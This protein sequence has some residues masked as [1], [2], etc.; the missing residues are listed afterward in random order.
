MPNLNKALKKNRNESYGDQ[1][2]M[3]KA[4]P[5][6]GFQET[7]NAANRRQPTLY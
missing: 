5:A 4:S 1:L 2:Q 7:A 3:V 6:C